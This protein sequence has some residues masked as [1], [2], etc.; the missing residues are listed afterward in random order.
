MGEDK[1]RLCLQTFFEEY[2]YKNALTTDFLQVVEKVTG[3]EYDA[4]F[5]QWLYTSGHPVLSLEWKQ[6]RKKLELTLRQHQE[7]HVFRF[8]LEIEITGKKGRSTRKMVQIDSREQ[9]VILELPFKAKEVDLDPDT[10]LLYEL[11]QGS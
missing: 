4:F 6:K 9:V 11:F 7:Q 3:K 10:W 8:P 5:Q 2:T 1:F